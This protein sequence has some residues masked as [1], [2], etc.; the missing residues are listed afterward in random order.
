MNDHVTGDIVALLPPLLQSLDALGFVARH[1]DPPELGSVME[2]I[3]KP[4]EELRSTHGK[5]QAWPEAFADVRA[6]L[7]TA[8]QETLA[9][10]DGLRAATDI[11][12]VYRA[13]RGYPQA[14]EALYTLSAHLA[15]VSHF[16][17]EPAA[18]A[19]TGLQARMAREPRDVN[20]QSRGA[21]NGSDH[22][23]CKRLV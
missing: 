19:D 8:T 13:L 22:T 21:R 6:R 4:D 2:A 14:Q 16:F 1:L 11:R 17:L 18:R 15:P 10:F 20:A 3:G 23:D 9:A 5:L 12:Q 7:D